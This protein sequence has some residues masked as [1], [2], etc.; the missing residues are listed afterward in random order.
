MSSPNDIIV[1]AVAALRAARREMPGSVALVPTMGNL[2]QGHLSLVRA[3]R[4]RADAV[5]VSVFVNPLQ[6]GPGEDYAAYPRTLDADAEVL[7]AEGVDLVFAPE[8]GQMYPRGDS[9]TRV[10]V[11]E[12]S[13]ILCG[14]SRPGHFEGVT[15]VVAML[16]NLVA[17]DYAFF[18]EK[19]YQQL[20]LIRRMVADLHMPVEIVGVPTVREADGLAMSSRNQYLSDAERRAAPSLHAALEAI[21]DRLRAGER[22]YG[23]LEAFGRERLRAAG[24]DPDYVAV[25]GPELTM[26]DEHAR[27]WRILGAG[28]LGRARL[29]DNIAVAAAGS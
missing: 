13:E 25:L 27:N 17:P 21:G 29:I 24:F 10:I 3:A 14:A 2:H 15:T 19:D 8:R 5:V 16:L 9:A 7:A 11:N 20:V 6:F 22:D 1:H 4:E 28:K 23:A 18:G 12:K 26:P